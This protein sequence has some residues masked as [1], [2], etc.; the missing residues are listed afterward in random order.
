MSECSLE[1]DLWYVETSLPPTH[2]RNLLVSALFLSL[3]S[4]V[5]VLRVGL[6]VE[7]PEGFPVGY[8]SSLLSLVSFGHFFLYPSELPFLSEPAKSL[9]LPHCGNLDFPLAHMLNEHSL[10]PT[11]LSACQSSA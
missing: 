9:R 11:S 3:L 7:P 10:P 5:E 1:V 4:F 2:S 8:P 6:P